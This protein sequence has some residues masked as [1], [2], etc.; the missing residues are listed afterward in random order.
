VV[1]EP[2]PV[3]ASWRAR[4]ATLIAGAPVNLVSRG[5]RADVGRIHVDEC[6]RISERL[7]VRAGGRWMDLGT[8]G[9]LPGLVLA[10]VFPTARWTLVDARRK[11]IDQVA[12]FAAALGLENVDAVHARAEDLGSDP[13]HRASYD[14]VISRA[15]GS[16]TVT[17]ALSRPFIT[18]GTVVAV[19]GPR[20]D[21]DVAAARSPFARIG[22]AVE[23]VEGIDGTIRPTWL[24]R[25]SGN[26]R[27]PAD[28]PKMQRVLLRSDGG[29]R[30]VSTA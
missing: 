17:G 23:K 7:T 16:L 5:D 18:T 2:R 30:G 22:L 11:K 15:A 3:D 28:F 9:G 27:V 8:G 19:R 26:G 4:L 24:V 10:H 6:V 12:G 1:V 13:E 29:G 21:E 20:V 14:G 25:L